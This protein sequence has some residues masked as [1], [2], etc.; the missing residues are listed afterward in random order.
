M[1]VHCPCPSTLLLLIFIFSNSL[2]W[3]WH[4]LKFW[5]FGLVL[6][7]FLM[8]PFMTAVFKQ[9]TAR[10]HAAFADH[11]VLYFLD[12]VHLEALCSFFI[13]SLS[14]LL[15][16]VQMYID[17]TGKWSKGEIKTACICVSALKSNYVN[18]TWPHLAH[19]LPAS[20]V[21]WHEQSGCC[22]QNGLP[23]YPLRDWI[24]FEILCIISRSF[25]SPCKF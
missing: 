3:L 6:V 20:Q 9:C 12:V 14:W 18:L 17:N 4:F 16:E 8:L 24:K 15:H 25:F 10:K 1:P 13:F 11:G 2:S 21:C 19:R 22:C 7:L 5:A 23:G